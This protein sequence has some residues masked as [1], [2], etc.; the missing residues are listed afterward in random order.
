MTSAKLRRQ[1][2][3]EEAWTGDAVLCLYARRRILRET[4]TVDSARFE[5][6]TSNRFL[7]SLGEPSEVEAEIGRVFEAEGLEKAFA[8]IEQKLMP[9]FDRQEEKRMR[10]RVPHTKT[11]GQSR[12]DSSSA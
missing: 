11:I 7:T 1:R 6:M 10:G 4:S 3:L 12:N 2:I 5:R 8:W 9:L